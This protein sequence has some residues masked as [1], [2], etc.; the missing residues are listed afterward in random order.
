MRYLGADLMADLGY[1][2]DEMREVIASR[3]PGF[4]FHTIPLDWLFPDEGRNIIGRLVY[5]LI[6]A[7]CKIIHASKSLGR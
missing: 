1:S 5:E 7:R 6:L 4:T 2:Y 3:R